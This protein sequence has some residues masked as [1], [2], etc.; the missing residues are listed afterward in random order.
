MWD[1]AYAEATLPASDMERAKRFYADRLD[2]KPVSQDETGV[3]FVVGGTRFRLFRS[4]G[5]AS[6]THT[7]LAFV[8]DDVSDVVARL[9]ARGLEFE[10][11][12]YPNLKTIDGIADLGY[13]RAAWF[14]DSEGNLLGIAQQRVPSF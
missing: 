2:F 7:Q 9:K 10:T 14:K 3:H 6:G 4:G 13:A 1:T 12:D 8:V 11:Y 5:V